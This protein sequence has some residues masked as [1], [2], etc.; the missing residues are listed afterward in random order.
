MA[1]TA[2][3]DSKGAVKVRKSREDWVFDI[4][5]Y[6]IAAALILVTLY[7]MYFIVIASFSNP[8][9]VSNGQIMFLPR[10][11]TFKAYRELASYPKLWAGYGNTIIYVIAG[12]IISLVVNIPASFALSRRRLYGKKIFT[13]FYLIPMF[14]TG[15]LIPTFLAVQEFGLVNTRMVMV[16]P[17]SVVTYYIIVGRTF[18]LNSIPEELWEAAQLD[19]CGYLGFFFRIVL[20]L[21]KAVISVIALWT[22]V[23]QWNGYFN[24]L[25]YLRDEGLQPLQIF[26]RNI[27]INNQRISAMTTGSAATEAKE[28]AD[29]IKYAIIVLSSAPIMCM[30]PFVQKYFNQGVMLGSVKG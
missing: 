28:M 5:I 21:S 3:V 13:I 16:L 4:M 12:T 8:T 7:P 24:A 19:G 18:F 10:G 2:A 27:L 30:Y 6:T 29:L 15:G 23:G 9:L 1:N 25:I 20:P 22:A 14:F 17:F 11:I 26:L